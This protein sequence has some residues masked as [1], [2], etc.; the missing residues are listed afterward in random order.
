MLLEMYKNA[1]FSLVNMKME[2]FNLNINSEIKFLLNNKLKYQYSM[3]SLRHRGH[4]V[5]F[6]KII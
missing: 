4:K 3:I 6:C 5:M 2:A 1:V